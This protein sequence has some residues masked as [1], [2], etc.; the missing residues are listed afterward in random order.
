MADYYF[1]S[2][3]GSAPDYY[4]YVYRPLSLERELPAFVTE[5]YRRI[6]EISVRGRKTIDIYAISVPAHSD[7][8]MDTTQYRVYR[9]G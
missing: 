9:I 6:R 1:H 7:P 8:M 4:I 5:R 3:R 2:S